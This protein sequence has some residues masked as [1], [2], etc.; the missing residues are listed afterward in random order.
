MFSSKFPAC[1]SLIM[2]TFGK[3]Y[4]STCARKEVQMHFATLNEDFKMHT[5]V[6]CPTART[7]S[8]LR[9]FKCFRRS[10]LRTGTCKVKHFKHNISVIFAFY[11]TCR[12]NVYDHSSVRSKL[13]G[14]LTFIGFFFSFKAIEHQ[15]N[16]NS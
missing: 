16:K 10:Q 6:S 1:A 3:P 13:S 7:N 5:L 4:L 11:S 14:K 12:T 8:T 2:S 15:T 9:V